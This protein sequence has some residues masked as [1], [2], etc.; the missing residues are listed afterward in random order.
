MNNSKNKL[1]NKKNLTFLAN[2]KH[3]PNVMK[4]LSL[5]GKGKNRYFK[6]K[7]NLNKELL[8]AWIE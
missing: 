5:F 4:F 8:I 6:K 2:A 3:N 1:N 7:K